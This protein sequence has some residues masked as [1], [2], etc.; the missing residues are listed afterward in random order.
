M[1]MAVQNDVLKGEDVFRG[2]AADDGLQRLA[3]AVIIQAAFDAR[4]GNRQAATW[5]TAQETADTWMVLAGGLDCRAVRAWV[6]GGCKKRSAH[7]SKK[8]KS[9]LLF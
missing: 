6:L 7:E 4:K 8:S 9:K 5:L 1:L 2:E 3:Q